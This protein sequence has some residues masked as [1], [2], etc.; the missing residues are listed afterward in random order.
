M[1]K[2]SAATPLKTPATTRILTATPTSTQSPTSSLIGR[3]GGGR[4]SKK[5]AVL[6]IT[7][8]VAISWFQSKSMETK[9]LVA[10]VYTPFGD[11]G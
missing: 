7:C 1:R 2:E 8:T 11:D 3:S 4:G 10:A 6:T 9:G 5:V